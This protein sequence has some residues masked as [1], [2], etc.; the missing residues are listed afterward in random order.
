MTDNLRNAFAVIFSVVSSFWNFMVNTNVPGTTISFAS[1][2]LFVLV[3]GVVCSV[4]EYVIGVRTYGSYSA[5]RAV[6]LQRK[7]DRKGK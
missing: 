2:S 7:D 6:K 3:F 1:L 4:V 5:Y